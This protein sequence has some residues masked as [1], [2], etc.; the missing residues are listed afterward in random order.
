MSILGNYVFVRS[1][2]TTY[3]CP[4]EEYDTYKYKNFSLIFL[5]EYQVKLHKKNVCT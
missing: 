4:M 2:F 5:Q 3:L 1:S